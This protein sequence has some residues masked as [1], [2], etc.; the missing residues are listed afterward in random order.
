MEIVSFGQRCRKLSNFCAGDGSS[1]SCFCFGGLSRNWLKTLSLIVSVPPSPVYFVFRKLF[2]RGRDWHLIVFAVAAEVDVYDEF[3]RRGTVLVGPVADGRGSQFFACLD[4][5][6]RRC[7]FVA[8]YV[9]QIAGGFGK[10]LRG[11]FLSGYPGA[12]P[13]FGFGPDGTDQR[14]VFNDAL[15]G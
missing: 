2:R 7:G 12:H 6:P 14:G 1:A 9:I 11:R 15:P 5:I 10:M 13:A 4:P 8:Q 3:V